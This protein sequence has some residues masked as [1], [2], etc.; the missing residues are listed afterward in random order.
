MSQ[1]DE[2]D[3]ISS[4]PAMPPSNLLKQYNNQCTKTLPTDSSGTSIDMTANT[5]GHHQHL[6]KDVGD[7][8]RTQCKGSD[9]DSEEVSKATNAIHVGGNSHGRTGENLLLSSI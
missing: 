5:A 6:N 9:S 3:E 2:D 1:E 7:T 8:T 4:T